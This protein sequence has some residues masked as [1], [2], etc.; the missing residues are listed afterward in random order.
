MMSTT[1]LL[2]LGSEVNPYM[3]SK[4]NRNLILR[5]YQCRFRAGYSVFRQPQGL[6]S[7]AV[8][9]TCG[10]CVKPQDPLVRGLWNLAL[11]GEG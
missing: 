2:R 4:L 8:W 5:V 6:T 9:K 11:R 1:Q 10:C 7:Q 3:W